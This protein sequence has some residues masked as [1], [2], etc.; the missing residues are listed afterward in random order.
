[1]KKIRAEYIE[2]LLVLVVIGMISSCKKNITAPSLT[3]NITSWNDLTP[4]QQNFLNTIEKT[5]FE[6][7][8]NGTDPVTGLGDASSPKENN[9]VSIAS[10]GFGLTSICIADTR[11]WITNQQAYA[12]VW[13]ILNSF[14]KN[15]NDST[16]FC[17]Q[18]KEG[19]FYHMINTE[20]GKRDGMSEVST[21]DSGLLM[22]G[23]LDCLVH[24]SGTAI[25][26]LARKI[27]LN[28]NWN[29]YIRSDGA[30]AGGWKPETG[31]FGEFRGYNEYILVYLLGLGSPT[32]SIPNSSWDVY[33]KAYH[34]QHPFKDIGPFVTPSA[35]L[36]PEAYLYQFPA[37][38]IDFRGM[39]DHYLDYW[40]NGINAL[41]AN[42]Q[43][44]LNWAKQNNYPDKELWGWTACAGKYGYLGFSAP[45]NG[46]VSPSAVAAALPFI[47]NYAFPT[48]K[49]MY[50][51]YGGEIWGKYGFTDAF[52][53]GQNWYDPGYGDASIDN[54]NLGIDQGNT[55]LMIENFRDEGVWKEF[56]SIPY[57]RTAMGKAG[58]VP[59]STTY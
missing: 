32:H 43:I 45:Y 36:I 13:K 1:M 4:D 35:Q 11:G 22:A 46:T 2:V 40:Q 19:L 54:G 48:L 51:K 49:Y 8:W 25:D 50:D 17:V 42:R 34:W 52:N 6:F 23:I 12:R 5:T 9:V 59:D 24:F 18:G 38:W 44:C 14:Y 55:V 30:I 10:E 57:I 58:F 26:T 3:S 16:D 47:P 28:A 41:E 20:T 37:C 31:I 21:I 39:K 7:F 53:V 15:P 29:Y 33:A 56:M 27:Y